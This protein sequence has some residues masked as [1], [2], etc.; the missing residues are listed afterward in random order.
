MLRFK[1][2]FTI[3]SVFAGVQNAIVR[4]EGAVGDGSAQKS[5]TSTRNR[6]RNNGARRRTTQKNKH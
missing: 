2:I 1:E 6:S 3:S 5:S 4:D